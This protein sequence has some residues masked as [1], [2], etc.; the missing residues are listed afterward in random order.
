MFGDV[1]DDGHVLHPRSGVD[2]RREVTRRVVLK[3]HA[4]RTIVELQSVERPLGDP[5]VQLSERLK[6]DHVDRHKPAAGGDDAM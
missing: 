6:D 4:R 2:R 5:V 3:K 1:N